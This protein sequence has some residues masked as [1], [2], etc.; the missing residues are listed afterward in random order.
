MNKLIQ[1][2]KKAGQAVARM[3]PS[4]L[5]LVRAEREHLAKLRIPAVRSFVRSL[6]KNYPSLTEAIH[7]MA[8]SADD[9]I[10]HFDYLNVFRRKA[11]DTKH[12]AFRHFIVV[13]NGMSREDAITASNGVMVVDQDNNQIM[14]RTPIIVPSLSAAVNAGLSITMELAAV[15][16]DPN[17]VSIRIIDEF[18]AWFQY[19]RCELNCLWALSEVYNPNGVF[20]D[21]EG[22]QIPHDAEVKFRAAYDIPNH[23][24]ANAAYRTVFKAACAEA[25]RMW[26]AMNPHTQPIR[27]SK[28]CD[29]SNRE[30]IPNGTFLGYTNR[31]QGVVPWDIALS[32]CV[33]F[34]TESG[35]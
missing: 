32:D 16:K 33:Q 15:T 17:I 24:D 8:I 22:F 19:H 34:I 30:L 31:Q 7:G 29:Y 21:L 25:E 14:A 2:I 6:Y 9:G 10:L 23:S 4:E 1:A 11:Y 5:E 27:L 35:E 26:I 20:G 28:P 12:L 3:E 18:G 13:T